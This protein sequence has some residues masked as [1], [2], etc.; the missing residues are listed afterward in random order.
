MPDRCDQIFAFI[1]TDDDGNE[2]VAA[3]MTPMGWMPLLGANQERIDSCR[4]VAQGIADATGSP[5]ELV[6]FTNRTSVE[7]LT[8]KRSGNGHG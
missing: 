3:Q 1:C 6:V 2:G 5:I 4:D 8:P 7:T